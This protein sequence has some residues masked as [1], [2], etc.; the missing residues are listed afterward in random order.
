MYVV[1]CTQSLWK[2]L[3]H[4]RSSLGLLLPRIYP[5]NYIC[6]RRM[7]VMRVF[8]KCRLH[9][10]RVTMLAGRDSTAL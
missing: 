4:P 2:R 8:I 6:A 9:S 10:L 5:G 7:S 3:R 1:I